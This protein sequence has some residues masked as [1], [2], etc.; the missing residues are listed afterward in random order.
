MASPASSR[1]LGSESR[2]H[3]FPDLAR[4]RVHDILLVSSLYDAFILTEDG[5]PAEGVLG[6]FLSFEPH[7]APRVRHAGTGTE[8]L[9]LARRA[10][11]FDLVIAAVKLGDM[12]VVELVRRLR[13]Q[14]QQ[15]PVVAMAYDASDLVGSAAP[16][17]ADGIDRV[18]LWQ[19]DVGILPAIVKYV[20]DRLNVSTDTGEMG[21]PAIILIEDSVR[22]YSSFLPVIYAELMRH[23]RSLV[24]EGIN[25][26]DKVMRQQARPKILLC[27]SYEEAWDYFTT[28]QDSVLGV[29]ADIEFPRQGV[30][31]PEAGVAFARHVRQL[32]PDVPIMLQSSRPENAP[33]AAGVPAAFVLKG[34]P[35]LLHE[36]QQFM[37]ENFGFGDFVFRMPDGA[38]VSRA[39]DLRT[40]EA[41]L[42]QVPAESLAY[43]GER[44][45]FSIW[46][47]AR[48]EFALAHRLR[49]RKVSDFASIEDL[50][51]ILIDAIHDY[52]RRRRRGIVAD[53]DR[54]TFDPASSFCRI[55]SG[56]LGGKG[57]S[58]AFLN[59]LIEEYGLGSRVPGAPI[60]VPPAVVLGTDVFD[61]MLD[62]GDLRAA[63]LASTDDRALLAR[64]RST[65]LP[66]DVR[67]A[68]AAYLEVA[69]YPLAVRSSSLLEDSPYQPFAG[70]YETVMVPNRGDLATRLAHV[71]EAIRRVYASTFTTRVKAYL[72]ASPYRHEEEKMAVVIQRVAGRPREDRYYPD[73]AGVAR[74]HNFY[75]VPPLEPRDGIAAVG[76]GLGAT[77]VGGEPCFRFSPRHP[78]HLIQFSSVQDILHNSQRTFYALRLD[79]EARRPD[80]TPAFELKAHALDVAER[81]GVL[82]SVGSTYSP[83]NDVI[84]D[85]TTRPGVRLVTFAPVLKHG[86][87]PL[88]EILAELLDVSEQGVGGPVELEFAVNLATGQAPAEFA[89]LQLRPLAFEREMATLDLGAADPGAVLCWSDTVLG[90]GRLDDLHDAVVVDSARFGAA[91]SQE[92]AA[93]IGRLNAELARS[94]T[95]YLLIVVGRLGSS[96]PTL[97]VPVV[98]DQIAGARAIV[99][100]GFRD[101]KVTPS[102]GSHFFQHLMT[103]RVGY[104]TVNAEAGEGAIDW[105]WLGA[106]PARSD[107]CGV[108]HLRFAAPFSV[109]MNG[110]DHR[111]IIVKPAAA[112]GRQTQPLH[113]PAWLGMS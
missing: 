107:R 31:S 89:L 65:P 112:G 35:T 12:G 111:G 77:V 69:R 4:Y 48:T 86:L 14:G 66:E 11:P 63:A 18:F 49:P 105:E 84:F 16:T 75:A 109:R 55:G 37:I 95:P 67:H 3:G 85:G 50:R 81:D 25:L 36:L 13:Q 62:T 78:R 1:W 5:Q 71:S 108:R 68:L 6:G 72:S 33:L 54:D 21:V 42:H 96:E 88:A 29:I 56:S 40:L 23:A 19:G 52:R 82:G 2:L 59:F 106:Q 45:H 104:F 61:R 60:G 24:P 100:A 8:A 99:E 47:K 91:R 41:E 64:F 10:G 101:F 113:G 103:F 44:N 87:F 20:E 97:G 46:L 51:R 94:H 90:H 110:K 15:V 93:E 22:Y 26:S 76:L 98:W 38:I 28:Y 74:S 79:D 30:A 17:E 57:R 39:G 53:F 7:D 102:Q 43:H 32:Q 92:I 58:L 73:L 70:V 34:S 80:G 9:D 83:E 27:G